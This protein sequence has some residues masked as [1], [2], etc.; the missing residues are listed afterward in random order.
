MIGGGVIGA[1][2]ALYLAAGTPRRPPRKTLL[3]EA[4]TPGHERGSSHGDGRIL[5]YTYS[6]PEYLELARRAEAAWRDLAARARERLLI[7][8]GSW[9]CAPA[10]AQALAEISRGLESAGLPFERLDP[11]KSARLFPQLRLEEGSEALYQPGGSVIRADAALETLWRLAEAAGVAVETGLRAESIERRGGLLRLEGAGLAIHARC[12]VLAAGSWSGPLLAGLGC[13]LP[14]DVRRET[15][16]YLTPRPGA[17]AQHRAGSMPAILDYHTERPFYALPQLRIPAVKIGWHRAG[18]AADPETPGEPA[19]IEEM[20]R[21]AARRLPELE[22]GPERATTCLYTNTPDY[23]FALGAMPGTEGLA[24][25]A[26][27]SG[28][29]FKFAPSLG[30]AAADLACGLEPEIQTGLFA[31]DRFRRPGAAAPRRSLA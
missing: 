23:H 18:A 7:E 5:R 19:G 15:V 11:E 17:S 25:A 29:G 2:A 6:E 14:L 31:L 20:G 10:G 30:E 1:A 4:L 16:V 3:L 8:T 21:W 28:H 24:V 9:E 22:G 13:P 12:A 27:F 26:G